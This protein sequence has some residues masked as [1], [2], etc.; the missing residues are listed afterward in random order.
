MDE[1]AKPGGRRGWALRRARAAH[2][3]GLAGI[4]SHMPPRLIAV[5]PPNCRWLDLA[6]RTQR[7][8]QRR[9]GFFARITSPRLKRDGSLF[10]G[11]STQTN[12][13]SD[14]LM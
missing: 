4:C 2:G 6:V 8:E 10:A 5:S 9:R 14:P 7:R 1:F 12:C 13:I 3:Q 11:P